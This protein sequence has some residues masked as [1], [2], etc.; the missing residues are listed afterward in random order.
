M[1]ELQIFIDYVILFYKEKITI[2]QCKGVTNLDGLTLMIADNSDEFRQ[3]LDEALSDSYKIVHC[4]NGKQALQTALEIKPEIIILD[5]ML[6]ELDGVSLLHE[7]RD[8]GIYPMVLAVTRFYN[9]Y[10]QETAQDLGIGYIIRKPCDPAA[11]AGRLRD[12][13]NRIKPKAVRPVDPRNYVMEQTRMLMFSPRHQGTKFIQEAILIVLEEP[14][15]SLTKELYPRLGHRFG[16]TALQVEHSLRTA[17]VSACKKSN[18]KVWDDMFPTN[19]VTGNRQISNGVVISRLAEDLRI[20]L[21]T[22]QTENS[23]P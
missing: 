8:A 13:T 7:I 11:V 1:Y 14:G 16:G 15:I 19:P 22:Q 5:L 21:E 18:G 17:I 9:D 10:I 12:L 23:L 4:R 2:L 6:T 20:K 3:A